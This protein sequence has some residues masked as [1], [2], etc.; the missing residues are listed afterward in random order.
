MRNRKTRTMVLGIILAVII[1]AALGALAFYEHK[2]LTASEADAKYFSDTL[3]ANTMDVYVASRDIEA[4]ERLYTEEMI[5]EL[6]DVKLDQAG[7]RPT[8]GAI[9]QRR[10][11]TNVYTDRIYTSLPRSSYI[12]ADML[13]SVTLVP[14]KA[15]EPIMANVVKALEITQDSREYEISAASLMVDQQT[16]D[17]V[18]VRIT[19]PNGEDYLVLSKK[20]VQ[21]LSLAQ[22]TF[23]TYMNEDEIMRF[24]SAIIDAYH[25]T[26]TR[27]YTVRYAA[28]S[29]Q[30]EAV[31]NYVVRTETLDLMKSDPNIYARAEET[32]NAAARIS[33]EARLGNLTQ[34]QL[35]ATNAGFGLTDTAKNAV[36]QANIDMHADEIANAA[37]SDGSLS[38]TPAA[39]APAAE[40]AAAPAVTEETAAAPAGALDSARDLLGNGGR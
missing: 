27:I 13:G 12:T 39:E 7:D 24:T 8:A 21:N 15:G 18:E 9:L 4:G 38:E 11:S 31:P 37:Q 5:A 16:N 22:S 19:Y 34:D 6:N 3:Q 23:W 32:M 26:G 14:I 10:A 36:L 1:C 30:N 17:V 2:K 25:M 29:L 28:E 40:P 20:R 35:A 33:L